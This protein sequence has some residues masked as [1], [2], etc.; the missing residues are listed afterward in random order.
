MARRSP[1]KRYQAALRAIKRRGGYTHHQAQEVYRNIRDTEKGGKPV[2]ATD[3]REL[4][5]MTFEQHRA[6]EAP[7]KGEQVALQLKGH[8]ELWSAIRD[9]FESTILDTLQRQQGAQ[10]LVRV[11]GTKFDK[12]DKPRGHFEVQFTTNYDDFFYDYHNAVRMEVES[13]SDAAYNVGGIY[14]AS[15]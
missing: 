12:A 10:L 14:V 6:S 3:V 13:D 9:D 11:V 7:L 5:D 1:Q 4:S 2:T 15:V 8:G